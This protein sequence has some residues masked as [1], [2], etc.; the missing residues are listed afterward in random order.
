MRLTHTAFPAGAAVIAL[1]LLLAS[2]GDGDVAATVEAP[3]HQQAQATGEQQLIDGWVEVRPEPNLSL[4]LRDGWNA[5][6]VENGKG[7]IV[8]TGPS[9]ARAVVW[10]MFVAS[11]ASMPAPAAILTSFAK[12]DGVKIN[13][14]KPSPL[15]TNAVRMFGEAGDTVAQATFVYTQSEV[16][17]VGYWYLSSASR[18]QYEAL[19]PVFSG[20]MKG[21][22]IYGSTDAGQEAATP[23]MSFVDW[24]EPNEGAY[25]SQAPKGWRVQGGVT[26]PSPLRL[27]DAVEMTSPDGKVYAFSGDP[28]LPLF[29]TPTQMERQLGM[30]EG[31]RNGEAIL[32]SYQTAEQFLPDYLQRRFRGRCGTLKIASLTNQADLAAAANAQLAA[33]TAPGSFQRADVALATFSCGSDLVGA[34]Q[35]ATYIGGTLPQFGVEGFGLWQVSGVAGFIAPKD[36]SA[37]GAEAIIAMLTSRKVDPQWARGNQEMVAQVNAISR[38]AANKLSAQIASRSPASTGSTTSSSAMSDDLSRRWQNSTMDQTDVVDQATGQTYKVDSGASYYWIDQQGSAIVGTNS[39][40]QPSVDFSVM[41][42]LP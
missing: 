29:K 35:M 7:P 26:R 6:R 28:T 32:L 39:P 38:D 16:G 10:P 40:A 20:L 18:D 22:R 19:Q 37:E 13:W 21:V 30:V 11:A 24:K 2:C 5:N 1:V 41:T 34:V 15:G 33:S 12:A 25:V 14:G 17:M 23:K 4:Q 3:V 27:L 9:G 42:Q 31:S 8:F 36:R